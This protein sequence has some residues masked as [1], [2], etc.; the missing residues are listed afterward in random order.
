VKPIVLGTD[1][2]GEDVTLDL[3]SL[4]VSHM[5]IQ[6]SSGGGKSR[7][8]RRL[9]EQCVPQ[10]PTIIIDP[11]GEFSSLR[12]RFD[13]LLVGEGGEAPADVRT[14]GALALKLRELRVPTICDLFMLGTQQQ[15]NVDPRHIWVREFIFGLLN[16]PRSTWSNLLLIID[17]AQLF[18]PEKGEEPSPAGP[19]MKQLALLARKRGIGLVL[20]THRVGIT[21]NTVLSPIQNILIGKTR[22]DVDQERSAKSLGVRRPERPQ[23]YDDLKR[24]K[25]GYFYGQGPAISDER[26]L[27]HF[28]DVTT[29]HPEPGDDKRSASPPLPSSR[30]LHL[31]PRLPRLA[32]ISAGE[33]EGSQTDPPVAPEEGGRA[34]AL[35]SEIVDLRR[36]LREAANRPPQRVEVEKLVEVQVMP[37]SLVEAVRKALGGLQAALDAAEAV[38]AAPTRREKRPAAVSG[39]NFSTTPRRQPNKESRQTE[40]LGFLAAAGGELPLRRLALFVSMAPGARAFRA[41]VT[42]AVASGFAERSPVSPAVLRLTEGGRGAA[43]GAGS[44]PAPEEILRR[45]VA[46][47]KLSLRSADAVRFVLR[48][49]QPVAAERLA[50]ELGLAPGARGFRGI[51][52]GLVRLGFLKRSRDAESRKLALTAAPELLQGKAGRRLDP[53]LPAAEQQGARVPGGRPVKGL[54][55]VADAD[56]ESLARRSVRGASTRVEAN[57]RTTPRALIKGE[58]RLVAILA[59]RGGGPVPASDLAVLAVMSL[60]SVNTYVGHLCQFDYATRSKGAVEL[61]KHGQALG[62]PAEVREAAELLAEWKTA[63]LQGGQRALVDILAAAGSLTRTELLQRAAMSEASVLTYVGIIARFGLVLREDQVLRIHPALALRRR[64]GKAAAAAQRILA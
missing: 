19:A 35:R 52:G 57:G 56:A 46:L 5:F 27:V 28:G 38:G 64:G 32:D 7:T 48:G 12:E 23:F 37:R 20:A 4:L 44:L 2:A 62:V 24:L 59:G 25:P 61:T 36:Q 18:A 55:P 43:G 40:L 14:A 3:R 9:A 16:A 29:T 58:R 15:G 13:F 8:L 60:A 53:Q 30:I 50:A 51:V 45:W 26:V 22:V 39:D 11:E 63:Y 17:E 31:L 1:P 47:G 10:V 49:P 34:R 41:L 6:A 54:Q 42:S 21:S 33:T